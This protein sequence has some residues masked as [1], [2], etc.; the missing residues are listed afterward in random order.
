MVK[1]EVGRSY[2]CKP[3]GVSH[4]PAPALPLFQ[5]DALNVFAQCDYL[6]ESLGADFSCHWIHSRLTELTDFEGIVTAEETHL[7]A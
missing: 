6:K 1:A 7:S 2:I 5:Q 3:I 4:E